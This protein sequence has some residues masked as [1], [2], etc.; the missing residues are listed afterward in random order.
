RNLINRVKSIG[1]SSSGIL[2]GGVVRDDIIGTHYRK[3][4]IDKQ[5]DFD[6]YWDYN[7]DVETNKRLIIPKDID[8]FFKSENN[9][10][11]F[12]KEVQ[13]LVQ[14]FNGNVSISTNRN[15]N[16]IKYT[17]N[18]VFLK[19][20]RLHIY[21]TVGNSLSQSGIRL[22]LDVDIIKVDSNR[23]N[24]IDNFSYINE[25]SRIEPP[26]YNLDFLSNIFICEK[27]NSM[28]ITR[29]SNCTGTPVDD[30][31]FSNKIQFSAKIIEDIINMRTHFVSKMDC[32]NTEYINCYRILKMVEYGWY[33][34]NIPFRV[35]GGNEI[36]SIDISYNQDKCC[37]CLELVLSEE[38]KETDNDDSE[39]KLIEL[40]TYKTK[41]NYLH[42][43]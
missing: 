7:Y 31:V 9:S 25:I 29:M 39:N 12:I 15:F 6:K 34:D 32:F 5:L 21:L 24:G 4:F 40:N 16:H 28:I 43:D 36:S 22:T 38:L 14:R 30:M 1:L 18:Y 27:S 8:I 33:I 23:N 35:I 2:F 42:Y 26:F 37:I 20:E 41:S 17:C 13:K 11:V 3:L 19:H 10:T